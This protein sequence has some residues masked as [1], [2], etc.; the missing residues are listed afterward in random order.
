[1]MTQDDA[2]VLQQTRAEP[3]GACGLWEWTVCCTGALQFAFRNIDSVYAMTRFMSCN[4][5]QA[6]QKPRPPKELHVTGYVTATSY[7]RTGGGIN[8]DGCESL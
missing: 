7:F 4:E 6:G 1:M 5:S 8:E 2:I 3:V